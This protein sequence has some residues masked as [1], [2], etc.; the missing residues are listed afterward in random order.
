M[1]K[2]QHISDCLKESVISL[3]GMGAFEYVPFCEEHAK[4]YI[5]YL[6]ELLN[7]SERGFDW[8]TLWCKC[9][10]AKIDLKKYFSLKS[11]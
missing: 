1:S 9:E 5:I 3:I 6:E 4:G 11:E 8:E 2:C 7:K 10:A